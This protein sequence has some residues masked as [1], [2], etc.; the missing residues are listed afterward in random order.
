[1]PTVNFAD[2]VCSSL[3]IAIKQPSAWQQWFMLGFLRRVMKIFKNRQKN[4]R[5]CLRWK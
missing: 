3:Y 2:Y 1:M 4:Y 5:R